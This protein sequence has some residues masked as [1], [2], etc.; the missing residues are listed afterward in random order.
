MSEKDDRF[1]L[2][3]DYSSPE[4]VERRRRLHDQ[5][6]ALDRTYKDAE[7]ALLDFEREHGDEL[8]FNQD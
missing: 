6:E 3:E 2:P 5:W 4:Q 8:G 7:K 1:R